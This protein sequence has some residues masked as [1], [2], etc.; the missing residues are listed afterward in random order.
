MTDTSNG[1]VAGLAARRAALKL[2]D[3]VLRRGQPLESALGMATQ[4]ITHP[5][6]RALARAI[7]SETLRRLPDLDA[8]IDSATRQRL[9][10]DAK[11]RFVIRIALAQAL[12]MKTPPHAAVATALPLVEGGP[13]RL[14]HGVLGTLLRSEPSLPDLPT[15]PADAAA[16]WAGAWG[17]AVVEDA[18]RA[19]SRPPAID[20]TYK[21]GTVSSVDGGESRAANH[22]RLPGSGD[23][24]SLRGFAEGDF[25]VQNLAASVP[26]RLLGDGAG[27]TVLDLC[28]APGGKTMQLAASGWAVTAVDQDRARLVRLEDNLTRTHLVAEITCAD[29]MKWAPPA[30]VDAILLDAPCSATGIFARHPDVLHRVGAREIAMLA[31]Q[32]AAMI[33]RASAWL[34]PGGTLIFATCSMEREEG[35]AQVAGALTHGLVIDRVNATELPNGFVPHPEGWVRTLPGDGADGFFIARFRKT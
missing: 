5:P 16:R 4:G 28:A 17:D 3:A 10:D 22:V 35:E 8:L 9:P 6:D 15:L 1:P 24:A 19:L 30:P 12:I 29:L 33:A 2:L 14:V 31:Q 23:I 13:R 18:Q 11:A 21:P 27:R 25:W 7:A 34:K 26:A 32:Q 20:L